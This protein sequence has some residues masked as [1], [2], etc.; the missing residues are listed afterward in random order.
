MIVGMLVAG[1]IGIIIGFVVARDPGAK[2]DKL[3]SL[4]AKRTKPIRTCHVSRFFAIGTGGH[5]NSTCE[6]S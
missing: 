4:G 5:R 6:S 3:A 1:G 2:I